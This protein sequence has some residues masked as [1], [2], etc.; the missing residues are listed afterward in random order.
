MDEMIFL[1]TVSGFDKEYDKKYAPNRDINKTGKFQGFV[2][3][4]TEITIEVNIKAN[5]LKRFKYFALNGVFCKICKLKN[6][7]ITMIGKDNRWECKSRITRLNNGNSVI[8]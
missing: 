1:R 6:N 2:I 5:I 7:P 4:D 8:V 3:K